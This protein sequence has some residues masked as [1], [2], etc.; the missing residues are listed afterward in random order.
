[1]SR[2]GH[3]PQRTCLGCGARD[4]QRKLIRLRLAEDGRLVVDGEHGRGGYLHKAPDCWRGFL[5]RKGHYRAF[6]AE[7]SKPIK[8]QL[9]KELSGR[10]WE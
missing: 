7:I 4:D 3:Q 8:E 9:I 2:T 6:H 5:G 10:D 1:M